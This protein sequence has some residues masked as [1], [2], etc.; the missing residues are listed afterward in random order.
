MPKKSITGY[1][2]DPTK[3]TI[4]PVEYSG[5]YQDIYKL[6][7]YSIFATATLERNGD[8]VYVDDEGLLTVNDDSRFFTYEGYHSP[9]CGK[10]LILGL[11]RATGESISPKTSIDIIK[12]KIKFYTLAEI[13][14]FL[15]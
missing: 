5:D 14:E 11:N 12:K 8:T 10:G 3:K 9:L 6:C 13:R 7:D 15:D 4:T 2:I 1:L